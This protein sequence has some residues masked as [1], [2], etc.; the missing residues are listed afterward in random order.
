MEESIKILSQA[1]LLLLEDIA[2]QKD[3]LSFICIHLGNESPTAVQ[4]LKDTLKNM[5]SDKQLP[6]TAALSK[7]SQTMFDSL[8]QN[9]D[10]PIESMK[11]DYPFSSSPEM[12]RQKLYVIQGGKNT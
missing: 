5:S 11:A 9:I 2:A 1:I 12:L 6:I 3:I 10:K 8:S 4:D 7:L